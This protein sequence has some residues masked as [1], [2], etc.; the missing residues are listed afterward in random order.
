MTGALAIR[1]IVP[2]RSRAR[3]AANSRTLQASQFRREEF[4]KA[5]LR[6]TSLALLALACAAG[7][8]AAQKQGG[9]LRIY[10]RDNPPSASI[11]EEATVSVNMPF[12]PVFNNLVMFDP[13]KS[14]E[15]ADTV[16]PD[17]ATSWS[18]DATN[19]KLTFKL[20]DGVKWH[21]G[22][23]FTAKDVQCTWNMLTGKGE[24]ADFR[25][26]PRQVWYFNL[27]DVTTNG[28]NEVTF[29]L[30]APQPSFLLLLA[31]G[32]SPIY[33]CHVPQN[34]MRTRPIG[35][36]PFKFVEFK[37]GDSIRLVRNPDYFKKGRP[38]L[39]GIDI[40]IIENRST[41]ILAFTTGDF[42]LTFPTDVSAP[43]M[44]DMKA[45]APKAVCEF[46][47]TGVSINLIVNRGS[48]P[49]D[50][51][52]IRKAMSLALD[53]KAFNTILNEGTGTIGGAMLPA[54]SGEWAMPQD[55]LEKLIGYGPDIE[56][57]RAEARKLMEGLGYGL[58]KRLKVKVSTRNI[59]IYRDPAVILIDQLKQIY[60]D[61]ELENVDTP[62]WYTKIGK[63]EYQIGL[64]LT[65]IAVDDPDSNL[66]E[67]YTCKSARNYTEYCNPEVD[68]LIFAQSRETDRA[69]RKELVWDVERL[70]VEDAARPIIE[71]DSG[72]TCWQ[73]HVKGFTMHE[74]SIY[75][76][77]RFE[78]VWLDK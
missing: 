9:T 53:R 55:R 22:K 41:R 59:A 1:S 35:T 71:Y 38:Y 2:H 32:Y 49:F 46:K 74:N 51:A 39:D 44:K 45:Q 10:H 8:A 37:R 42:D 70:L 57:N 73:A 31:S 40:K 21:D 75:N 50:N 29:N 58:S 69:K 6:S 77:T 43:L 76:N 78:D 68:K 48:P 26:N 30:K 24:A 72:G 64:N 54:P 60:I 28:D 33:P 19:T 16:V 52:D 66:V 7:P 63:K 65:G 61:G 15:S 56:K 47:S 17:M 4:M 11:L 20:H 5:C 25:K 23:P 3:F 27:E 14:H 36:G 34:V 12:M 13:A 67:N 62:Q 18:W